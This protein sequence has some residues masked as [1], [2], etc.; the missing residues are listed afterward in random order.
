MV[1]PFHPPSIE[2]A[3]ELIAECVRQSKLQKVDKEV[4]VIYNLFADKVKGFN[5]NNVLED[6]ERQLDI[7]T[8]KKRK[9]L[10]V[11]CAVCCL[12]C[13]LCDRASCRKWTREVVV[14]FRPVR[15]Q[16]YGRY[17]KTAGYREAEGLLR[18][19]CCVFMCLVSFSVCCVLCELCCVAF[20][21]ILCVLC[22]CV[23]AQAAEVD[24][25]VVV[26]CVVCCACPRVMSS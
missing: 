21:V 22:V 16:D 9:V 15:G 20:G 24:K 18:A 10:S 11:F 19:V 5:L 14:I 2:S 12:C 26:C 1:D 3:R 4:V 25:V 8:P 23:I 13:V 7:D 17:R 6:I